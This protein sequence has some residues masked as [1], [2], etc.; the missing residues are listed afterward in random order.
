[1]Y[2]DHIHHHFPSSAPNMSP[3]HPPVIYI[4]LCPVIMTCIRMDVDHQQEHGH[5]Q[6]AVHT[7]GENWLSLPSNPQAVGNLSA[8][9][10][11][12][13]SCTGDHS[14]CE[15]LSPLHSK[16]TSFKALQS[17]LPHPLVLVCHLLFSSVPWTLGEDGLEAL[18]MTFYLNNYLNNY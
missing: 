16:S 18:I 8:R 17:T 2:Y 5:Q 9:N 3:F 12:T 10:L 11:W 6:P 1:M 4:L 15:F 7:L 13:S 14:C